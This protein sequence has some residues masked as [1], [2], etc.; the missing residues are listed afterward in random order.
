MGAA[1]QL[2]VGALEVAGAGRPDPLVEPGSA[3]DALAADRGPGLRPLRQRGPARLFVG[4]NQ[5]RSQ[6]QAHRPVGGEV[7]L[8][9]M[10]CPA[11]AAPG[12]P[13][14]R[15]GRPDPAGQAAQRSIQNSSSTLTPSA[16]ASLIASNADGVNTPF[17]TVFTVL[18]VTP[19]ARSQPAWVRPARLGAILRLFKVDQPSLCARRSS[20]PKRS[21]A[22]ARPNDR[23]RW[24]ASRPPAARTGSRQSAIAPAIATMKP[25]RKARP[26]ALV[27][28]RRWQGRAPGANRSSL[29]RSPAPAAA[30]P[31]G[32]ATPQPAHDRQCG[33]QHPRLPP[34]RRQLAGRADHR[35]RRKRPASP[36]GQLLG[37]GR[38]AC[39]RHVPPSSNLEVTSNAKVTRMSSARLTPRVE[40]R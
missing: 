2:L 24:I 30:P 1:R 35:K 16:L 21:S 34:I 33:H 11:G 5:R 13:G 12:R 29:L 14:D 28:L 38:V 26:D 36:P 3:A 4:P 32:S 8:I 10:S 17:S 23:I 37:L 6:R 31:T 15:P 9:G 20:I 39:A 27:S 25:T 19:T 40:G 7:A 18:R 22:L